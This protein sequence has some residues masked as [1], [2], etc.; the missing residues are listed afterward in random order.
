M[1]RGSSKIL[2][3]VVISI[4]IA[5]CVYWLVSSNNVRTELENID[6]C[7]MNELIKGCPE[8]CTFVGKYDSSYTLKEQVSYYALLNTIKRQ[9]EYSAFRD[10]I[11]KING[12]LINVEDLLVDSTISRVNPTTHY[13][14]DSTISKSLFY[15]KHK[16][17][18]KKLEED[19]SK[20]ERN[21][22]LYSYYYKIENDSCDILVVD[23]S[24][25]PEQCE[26]PIQSVTYFI[27]S[28]SIWKLNTPIFNNYFDIKTFI[29]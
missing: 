16:T 7:Y 15:Q 1:F 4:V 20:R 5:V 13:F 18:I 12:P 27:Y 3:L 10:S 11:S 6:Q 28:D 26:R 24:G 19:L 14:V 23:N 2:F 22:Y 17:K 8:K 9:E 25:Y 21:T 29:D